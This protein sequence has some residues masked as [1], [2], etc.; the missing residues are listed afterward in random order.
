MQPPARGGEAEARD[1]FARAERAYRAGDYD[2]AIAE[3]QSAYDEQPVPLLLFDIAQSYRARF[4][5]A[6]A[7]TDLRRAI[8]VFE[9]YLR[10]EHDPAHRDQAQ[11]ILAKLRARSAELPAP[12]PTTPSSAAPAAPAVAPGTPAVAP[13]APAAPVAAPSV[14]APAVVVSPEALAPAVA[15]PSSD[16]RWWRRWWLWTGVGAAVVVGA[17]LGLGFGLGGNHAGPATIDLR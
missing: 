9:N 11:R 5:V 13:A 14:L 17:G 4:D 16:R 6:G 12:E 1:H 15:S 3:Y 10:D 2:T 8:A 7:P